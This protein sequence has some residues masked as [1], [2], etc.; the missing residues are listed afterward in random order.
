MAG[1]IVTGKKIVKNCSAQKI[2]NMTC[3]CPKTECERHGICC[4]CI[5]AHKEKKEV[6]FHVKFPHCLRDQ[7]AQIGYKP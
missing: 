4:E 1:G 5:L 6:A 2:I 3:S 7:L